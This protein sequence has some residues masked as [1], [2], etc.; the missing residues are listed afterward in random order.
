MLACRYCP[1]NSDSYDRNTTRD[2]LFDL[3]NLSSQKVTMEV[4]FII[5]IIKKFLQLLKIIV[6]L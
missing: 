1:D 2:T 6:H 3:I 4:Y 5:E